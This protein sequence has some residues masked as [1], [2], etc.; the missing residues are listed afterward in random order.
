MTASP[1]L[2]AVTVFPHATTSNVECKKTSD[3]IQD[4]YATKFVDF[5]KHRADTVLI[6][7]HTFYSY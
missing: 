5:K 1:L 7:S 2:K 6:C 4:F 3:I